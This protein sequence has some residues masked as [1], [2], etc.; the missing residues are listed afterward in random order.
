MSIREVKTK[1]HEEWVQLRKNSIGGS[2]A[3]AIAGFNPYMAAHSLWAEK[4]GHVAGFEGNITTEV[5]SFLEPFVAELFMRETGKKVR[6]RNATVFNDAYPWAHAN[7]DRVIIGENALLECK[8]TNSPPNLKM[9]RKGEYPPAWYCQVMHYMTVC[10]Y[11]KAYIAVLIACKDFQIFEVEWDEEEAN[12]LM[13]LEKKFWQH[14]KDGTPPPVSGLKCDDETLLAMHP[15]STPG[16]IQLWG[17]EALFEE[18]NMI[19][20]QQDALSQQLELLKQ[21]IKLDLGDYDTGYC[22]GWKVTWRTQARRT[23]DH[24]RFAKDNPGLS[25]AGY[26]NESSTRVFKVTEA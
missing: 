18:M 14:V 13:D 7:V 12:A 10:G 9:F 24:K 16:N 20:Q 8:T 5:G 23:F 1:T 6:R 3:G 4:S 21:Q 15:E 22:S 11:R 17:R 2:D 26:Y 25:L 19:K